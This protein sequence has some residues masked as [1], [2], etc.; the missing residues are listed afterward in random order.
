[1]DVYQ[2]MIYY[3]NLWDEVMSLYLYYL[4]IVGPFLCYLGNQI[5][6]MPWWDHDE[7]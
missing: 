2:N 4:L 6:V 1:M 5:G 3:D 7:W